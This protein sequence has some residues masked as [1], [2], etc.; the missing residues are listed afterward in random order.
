MLMHH[1]AFFQV[2]GLDRQGR[3]LAA[4][5]RLC[6]KLLTADRFR[7]Q[8]LMLHAALF[9]VAGLDRQGRDLRAVH[10]FLLKLLAAD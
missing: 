6:L 10:R 1:T 5:H 3:D 7:S 4:I 8:M 2:A 9:Q